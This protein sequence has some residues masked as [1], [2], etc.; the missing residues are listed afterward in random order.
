[1]EDFFRKKVRAIATF[2]TL[3][4]CDISNIGYNYGGTLSAQSFEEHRER[5]V[6]DGEGLTKENS[7]LAN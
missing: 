6:K 1:M 7:K 2:A 5:Q 4:T 3:S